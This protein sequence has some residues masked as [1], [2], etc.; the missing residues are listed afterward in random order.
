MREAYVVDVLRRL[1][2][3]AAEVYFH[4]TVGERLDPLGPNRGDLETLLS[5]RVRSTIA[6][7]GLVLTNYPALRRVEEGDHARGPILCGDR[8]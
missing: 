3:P 8:P 1:R 2:E 7:R 6:A 5:P 4:P